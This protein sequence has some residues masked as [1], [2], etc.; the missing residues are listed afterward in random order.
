MKKH[1]AKKPDHHGPSHK[2]PSGSK[3]S[4]S[5]AAKAKPPTPSKPSAPVQAPVEAAPKPSTPKPPVDWSEALDLVEP[6]IEEVEHQVNEK[7]R[8][9]KEKGQ[10]LTEVR[11]RCCACICCFNNLQGSYLHELALKLLS[12]CRSWCCAPMLWTASWPQTPP[13]GVC[14]AHLAVYAEWSASHLC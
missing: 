4:A 7:L 10:E 2:P 12:I 13:Q 9:H 8:D 11:A 1:E 3:Q 5:P 6:S 14:N